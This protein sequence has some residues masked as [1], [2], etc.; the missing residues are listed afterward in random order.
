M[1]TETVAVRTEELQV[2]ENRDVRSYHAFLRAA[3]NHIE[4]GLVAQMHDSY[5]RAAP[6]PPQDWRAAEAVLDE[7]VE[8]QFYCWAYRNLQRF[9]YHRPSLGIFAT[10]ERERERLEQVLEEAARA[11]PPDQLRL[12]PALPL[13]HYFRCVPFHQ[14]TG[15]VTADPLAGLAYEIGR[16][17]TVPAHADPNGIYRILFDALP[18]REYRR[19]LDWGTGHGAALLTWLERH[20]DT[21][22]HGVDLS[23]PCLK[24]ANL[25]ARER[26]ATVFLAQQDLEHLDY[27][28][29]HF[30]LVFFNFML[31]ELPPAHTPALLAEAARILKP[32]GLFAGHEFH[33][34]PGDPFQNVLQRSHAWTNNETYSTPWYDTPI[35]Q[36]AREAGFSAVSITPFERLNRSVLRPGKAPINSNHWNLYVFEK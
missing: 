23:A 2:Q 1:N 8:F 5:E 19:V 36:W 22:C 4:G 35:G 24:V 7:L 16:R 20:P 17:T 21:E 11:T 27:P 3:R 30:D 14:H 15:G 33:L 32:G 9:K 18:P 29:G 28:D 34:R 25:R 6:N 26:G 13:P 12:N 10:L 31:H